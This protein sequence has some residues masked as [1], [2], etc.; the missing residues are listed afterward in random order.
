VK[1]WRRSTVAVQ[2]VVR[3]L[4]D[5]IQDDG[6]TLRRR[7]GTQ[8][9]AVAEDMRSLLA[10]RLRRESAY[11][12]LWDRFE[13]E[14]R[15]VAAELTGALEAL[16][17]ADPALAKR[18][19]GFIEEYHRAIA[20]S[21]APSLNGSPTESP[22][23]GSVPDTTSIAGDDTDTGGGTYLYGNVRSSSVASIGRGLRG[24]QVRFADAG[25]PN[26]LDIDLLWD[27]LQTTVDG[28]HDL[29]AAV[30]S[31]LKDELR[32]LLAQILRADEDNAKALTHHLLNIR[33]LDLDTFEIALNQMKSFAEMLGPVLQEAIDHVEDG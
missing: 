16:L 33:R 19:N 4:R 30:R 32:K 29:D 1:G 25:G 21:G 2:E 31:S 11:A 18:L 8:A 14:P 13:I 17:E 24:G 22:V 12:S 28:R 10:A 3:I 6:V 20:P 5:H 15:T 26:A 27:Q 23:G 9:D 7:Y